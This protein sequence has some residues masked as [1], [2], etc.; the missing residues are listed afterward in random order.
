M[1]RFG[2]LGA[3]AGPDPFQFFTEKSLPPPLRLLGNV[4]PDRFRFQV[5]RVIPGM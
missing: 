3:D 1:P 4:L 5:S 2:T